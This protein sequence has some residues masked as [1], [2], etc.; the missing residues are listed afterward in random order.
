MHFLGLLSALSA[1]A[2]ASASVIDHKHHVRRGSLKSNS[3]RNVAYYS[4]WDIYSAKYLVTDVPAKDL[5]HLIYAFAN[6]SSTTGKVS[7]SDEYA[8]LQYQY[9]GDDPS[10][11]GTN[12]YGNVKQLFLL[13]KKQ[14]NL[15]TMISIGGATYSEYMVPVLASES[16]R[17]TFAQSAVDLV[18]N[19][20]FDGIDIDYE[21]ISSAAQ[22]EQF[23]DLLRKLR[24]RLDAFA[25]NISASPFSLSFAAPMGSS[26]YGLLDFPSIDK[27]LDFWNLMG[28]AYTGSWNTDAGFQANLFNSTKNPLSTPIDSN[29][30]IHYYIAHGATPSKLVLGCPLYGV[31]FNN[32]AGPGKPFH[33]LGTEGTFGQAGLWNYNDL[34]APGF[35]ATT[36]ELP[37][38]GASYSYDP[39]KKYMISYDTPNIAAVKAEYTQ[40]MGLGGLM[41]WEVSMDKTGIS[42]LIST[43]V[44][45][46]GGA[47]ALDQSLNN[48][49]YPTSKY[50][51]LKAGFA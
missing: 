11:P 26:Y 9:P 40:E 19:L 39:K 34:P 28:Y 31:S 3:T 1:V 12:V 17:E 46:F 33:G 44:K 13:K 10:A 7:L 25:A 48:L 29:T 20:G 45:K 15:K 51:N 27:Y 32:T 6:I 2:A 47:N 22:M 36:F 35:N 18:T 14:R 38:I 21:S 5:T 37:E 8:D 16:L 23:T 41:W 50:D 4:N 49:N 30:S 43:A 42:S 24:T